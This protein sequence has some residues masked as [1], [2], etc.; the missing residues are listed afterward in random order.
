MGRK[1]ILVGDPT[2]HG[3]SVLSGAPTSTV[4]GKPV[5]RLGD[6]VSCPRHGDNSIV[7]GQAAYAINGIPAALEGHRTKCGATLIATCNSTVG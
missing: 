6:R 5:A 7:E 2:S 1:L 4:G 3:G